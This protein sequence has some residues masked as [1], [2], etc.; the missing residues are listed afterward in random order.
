MNIPEG[1]RMEVVLRH[2]NSII[3][4]HFVISVE[5]RKME[6]VSY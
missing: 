2:I 3:I 6:N 5:I 4:E 1:V